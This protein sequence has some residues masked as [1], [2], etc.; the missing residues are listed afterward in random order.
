MHEPHGL[1]KCADLYVRE[2]CEHI[3]ECACVMHEPHGLVKC[4]NLHEGIGEHVVMCM[5][6]KKCVCVCVCVIDSRKC[7]PA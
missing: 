6:E 3:Y 5:Y 2:Q 4:A 1:V 7:Q